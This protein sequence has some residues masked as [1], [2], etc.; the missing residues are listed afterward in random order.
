MIL[1]LPLIHILKYFVLLFSPTVIY[2]SLF[3]LIHRHF[4]FEVKE[5]M[6]TSALESVFD[7]GG[8][9]NEYRTQIAPEFQLLH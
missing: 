3:L 5:C 2:F 7:T 9:A 6:N 8:L 1:H 4:S